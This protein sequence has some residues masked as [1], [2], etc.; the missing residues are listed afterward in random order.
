MKL[1]SFWERFGWDAAA[2]V[3]HI[4]WTRDADLI[5]K[6]D[7]YPF[8]LPQPPTEGRKRLTIRLNHIV[9]SSIDLDWDEVELENLSVS[10]QDPLLWHYGQFA[11]VYGSSPV[12]DPRAFVTAYLDKCSELGVVRDCLQYLN[13]DKLYGR[14]H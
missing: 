12:P 13:A 1:M 3:T 6:V 8:W 10:T 7:A 4:E 14:R 9:E 11:T 2:Q 5:V